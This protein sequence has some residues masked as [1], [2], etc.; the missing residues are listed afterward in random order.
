MFHAIPT[1][2][3]LSSLWHPELLGL[4]FILAGASH[5]F[6]Q[7]YTNIYPP[8]GT[9]GGLWR[10]PGTPKFHVYWTGVAEL[11]GGIGLFS[12][13]SFLHS[14]QLASTF[15]ALLLGL[16]V[17]VYPSNL[18]MFTHGAELPKGVEMDNKGHAIRYAAQIVLC[19]VLLSMVEI[20]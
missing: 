11:L 9:W 19:A 15:S 2:P 6:V 5:F 13:Q 18:Y 7:D 14:P 1:I 8:Q 16:S 17:A 12:S 20:P 4:I 10:L 3:I